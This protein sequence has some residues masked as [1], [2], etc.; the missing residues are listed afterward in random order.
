M[1]CM[2]PD[3]SVGSQ[4]DR[5]LFVRTGEDPSWCYDNF[6]NL[7]ALKSADNVR[8]QLTRIMAR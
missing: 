6:L 3:P 8:G 2:V 7:R 5:L 4:V 1:S